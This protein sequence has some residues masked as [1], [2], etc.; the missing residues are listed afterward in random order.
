MMLVTRSERKICR[1]CG[2]N[3]DAG[4]D[5]RDGDFG[6]DDFGRANDGHAAIWCSKVFEWRLDV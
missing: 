2:C 1:G 6:D 4:K 3:G 5:V